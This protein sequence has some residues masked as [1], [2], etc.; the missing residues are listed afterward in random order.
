FYILLNILNFHFI[1]I[2]RVAITI[3]LSTGAINFREVNNVREDFSAINAPSRY[4]YAVTQDFFKNFGSPF[5]LVVVFEAMDGGS[6]L[7]PGYLEKAIE[8]EEY[9]QTKLNI[10]QEG[11]TYSYSDFCQPYC[12]TSDVVNIFLNMYR[13][14]EIRKKT[15][16]K[17]TYPTMDLFG[18]RIYL[19]NN[20]FKVDL[21]ERSQLIKGCGIIAINFH[22]IISN[23]SQAEI[24]NKWEHEVLK[25]AS[26]TKNNNLIR[27]YATSEALV[28]EEIRKTGIQAIPLI[29]ISLIAVLIFTILTSLKCDPITSKPFE[30]L[31]GVFCPL[32]S[33]FASFGAL[34]WLDY[35]FLPIV[36]VVP[37]LILAIGVDDVFI[38]L[39]CYH[40]SNRKLCV[41]E[42]IA[43]MLAEAGPSITI[44][45]LTNFLSFSISALT[46]TPAIKI[47]SIFISVA[48]VFD[49][50]YQIFFY[51]AVLTLGGR[52]EEKKLN[53]WILCS[54]I[55]I[56]REVFYGKKVRIWL[57]KTM[58]DFV[59][60][61]VNFSMSVAA[62]IIISIILVIYWI[63]S[64]YGLFQIKVG[65]SSEKL[66][67]DDSE[68]LPFVKIQSTIIFKEGGQVLVFVN[69]PGD[70]TEKEAVPKIMQLLNRFEKA[71][72]S[73]GPISTHMWLFSYL[74]YTGIQNK[75]SIEF[76]YKYLPEFLSFRE[77]H[78]WNYFL[79]LGS[80]EDC[81][82]E[83]PSCVQKFFFTTGF[84]GAVAWSDRLKLLIEWRAIASEYKHLNV[85]VYE[86][87]SMYADQLLTIVPVTK[88][89]VTF[90]FICM[91]IVLTIFTPCI[92]TIITS[93]LSILSINLGVIGSLTYWN[94]DLDPISMATTL[95]SIGF[96]VDFIAHITF[97]YYKGEQPD[98]KERLRHAFNSIA[99]PMMQ[100]GV[101]TIL[102]LC[103]LAIIQA[104]MVKVFVKV[105]V[106]VVMLGLFHGLIVLPIVFGAL[107]INKKNSLL[108]SSNS[109]K[110]FISSPFL[111]VHV[112]RVDM[113]IPLK[114][115]LKVTGRR[116]NVQPDN[117]GDILISVN[118]I[119]Y[120]VINVCVEFFYIRNSNV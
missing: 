49:Y 78:R 29:S 58:R 68:I 87:F 104:Y 7:R 83:K 97:H 36:C 59:H 100:A 89:T 80:T 33:M 34:F 20:I 95:M 56:K 47:F 5:H 71:S 96:S 6:L 120:I 44:T 30:A 69:K 2:F 70:L 62:R 17:L 108:S 40:R 61:W 99:W 118:F 4:E 57:S 48:V 24:I 107:P 116:T 22:A 13:A 112:I 84:K 82:Q 60:T 113:Q 74:P 12:E 38:F 119:F 77:Y 110:V 43:N 51:S 73:V 65:L 53:A 90:A 101:S 72:G 21:Y 117:H 11:Q 109:Q 85:T 8:I 1:I 41:E 42:R 102:S 10:S 67:M 111:C 92:T 94:V 88:S 55:P 15:K 35:P 81:L 46:P 16:V 3:V 79:S 91:A 19:A 25:F 105:V 64:A 32:I 63:I 115:D 86:P 76:K 66:F 114:M 52:R 103:V 39:H 27:V 23:D 28:S 9:L 54:N 18:H 14:V 98:K 106:L 26:S 31:L 50:I 75:G 37:F 93:T 45:S